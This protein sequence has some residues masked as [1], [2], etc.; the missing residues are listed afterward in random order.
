[1]QANGP[2]GP[3]GLYDLTCDGQEDPILQ[4]AIEPGRGIRINNRT[5]PPSTSCFDF[6]TL[7]NIMIRNQTNCANPYTTLH[8]MR[9]FQLPRQTV[10]TL[11]LMFRDHGL[12]FPP[13]REPDFYIL[14]LSGQQ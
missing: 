3:N 8:P 11:L 2:N 7:Y 12:Q 9:R 6:G 13:P 14:D 10:D 1:M 4:D 5:N